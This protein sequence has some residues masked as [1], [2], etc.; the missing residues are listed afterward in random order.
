MKIIFYFFFLL[1]T[2]LFAQQLVVNPDFSELD[3]KG[4]PIGWKC[5]TVVR[6]IPDADGMNKAAAKF[7]DH[8]V[9][10]LKE[11]LKKREDKAKAASEKK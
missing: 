2:A 5:D 7:A 6:I 1:S 9:Y 8:V 10:I 11:E 4:K 3:E